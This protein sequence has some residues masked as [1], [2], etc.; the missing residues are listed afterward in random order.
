MHSQHA[1]LSII[2]VSVLCGS[3]YSALNGSKE[4]GRQSGRWLHCQ[5]QSERC[6]GNLFQ[7]ATN[8]AL[9]P[10]PSPHTTTQGSHGQDHHATLSPQCSQKRL[11]LCSFQPDFQILQQVFCSYRSPLLVVNSSSRFGHSDNR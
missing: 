6:F 3:S 7:L 4:G 2:T 9:L 8:Q 11:H 5:Q 10:S 1:L